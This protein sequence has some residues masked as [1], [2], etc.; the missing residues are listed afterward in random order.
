MAYLPADHS[1]PSCHFSKIPAQ[2][3]L[4]PVRHFALTLKMGLLLL[5]YQRDASGPNDS[6]GGIVK[7]E[8]LLELTD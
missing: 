7:D 1:R 5:C 4:W 2:V 8:L 3:S 6:W